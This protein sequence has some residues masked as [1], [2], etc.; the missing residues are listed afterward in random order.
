[1]REHYRIDEWEAAPA[2]ADLVAR[3]VAFHHFGRNV[4]VVDRHHVTIARLL[5]DGVRV[6]QT[7]MQ[8]EDQQDKAMMLQRLAVQAD[9][10]GADELIF[11]SEAWGAPVVGPEDPR[12]GL[13]PGERDDRDEAL[14]TYAAARGG[15]CHTWCSRF[16]RNP[17]GAILL[18]EADHFTGEPPFLEP[19]PAV[20]SEWPDES[21][22]SQ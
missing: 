4:L 17:G 1:M 16:V 20:W 8:P 10:L 11:T 18:E 2:G 21:S 3:A 9:R 12:F 15:L 14:M 6:A 5:R 7:V 22:V 19:L 13:R